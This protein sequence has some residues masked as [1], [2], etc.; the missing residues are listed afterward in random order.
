GRVDV[1]YDADTR[2]HVVISPT[3]DLQT[4]IAAACCHLQK[5]LP[6]VVVFAP[7]PAA[8]V[9]KPFSL[10]GSC[11]TPMILPFTLCRPEPSSS[12]SSDGLLCTFTGGLLWVTAVLFTDRF[13]FTPPHPAR[14]PARPTA[15]STAATILFARSAITGFHLAPARHGSRAPVAGHL[16]GHVA[17]TTAA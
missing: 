8:S 2:M 10:S 17:S 1:M 12:Y 11:G 9:F 13:D 15:T 14:A 16:P 7:P 4:T 5:P 3:G 6:E